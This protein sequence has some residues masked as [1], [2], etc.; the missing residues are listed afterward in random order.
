MKLYTVAMSQWRKAKA[1]DIALYDIT[2]KSGNKLY[3][4]ADAVL[5]AYKRGE[6]SDEEYTRLYREKLAQG[7]VERPDD[8]EAFLHQSGP[9]AV[10]CYCR[11]GTFCHRHL[12]ITFMQTVAE[13]NEIPFEYLGEIL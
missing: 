1:Q 6:V 5:W 2:V 8:F 4:P 10:A 11:A 12:F 7:F 9:L 13:D 3:A